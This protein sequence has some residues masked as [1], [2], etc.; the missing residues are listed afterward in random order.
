L[1]SRAKAWRRVLYGLEAAILVGSTP[2]D[3]ATAWVATLAQ[4]ARQMPDHVAEVYGKPKVTGNERTVIDFG[5]GRRTV[6]AGKPFGGAV[7]GW[8]DGGTRPSLIVLDDIETPERVRNPDLRLADRMKLTSDW[9]KLGPAEGGLEAWLDGTVL[10]V[11]STL[12]R[13]LKGLTRS[14]AGTAAAGGPSKR[15]PPVATCGTGTCRSTGRWGPRWRPDAPAPI[16]T[17]L[18]T[19]P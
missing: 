17:S 2:D 1:I 7:R 10:H 9:M 14:E 18:R 16:A 15:S 19:G 11:D 4:W 12:E 13:A 8:N 5:D 3:N 6:L